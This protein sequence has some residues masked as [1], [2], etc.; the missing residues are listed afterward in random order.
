MD[1]IICLSEIKS[2]CISGPKCNHIYHLECAKRWLNINHSCPLCK[3]EMYYDFSN[4]H[5]IRADIGSEFFDLLTHEEK[6]L[7]IYKR[8]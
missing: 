5:K 1:C 8:L 6:I 2:T 3:R 7:T 4:I